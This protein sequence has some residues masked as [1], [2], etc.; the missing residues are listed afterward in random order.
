[1]K[2][3]LLC[4]YWLPKACTE[5]YTDQFTFICPTEKED[6][7]TQEQI[8]ERIGDCDVFFDVR[9]WARRDL[10]EAGKNLKVIANHAVG[11]DAIDVDCCNE[12]GIAVVLCATKVTETTAE[13]AVA[14]MM[15]TMRSVARYDREIRN[16]IWTSGPWIDTDTQ[17]F[18]H[19]LGVIGFG[20][21]GRAFAK[22]A[23]GLGMTIQ[24]YDPFRASPEVEREYEA[25]YL[26]LDEL[27][28]SSDCV[29]LHLPY[30][31]ENHNLINADAFAKMRDG[32]YLI[33][34]AR[35]P[36]VDE[37]AMIAALKSGKLRGAGLDVFVGEPQVNPELLKLPNVVMTPHAGSQTLETRVNMWNEG[38]EGVISVLNGKTPPNI[39]NP[40]VMSK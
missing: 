12:R 29:T 28:A 25:T 15:A 14:L 24:Y 20:R 34:A 39:V 36:I 9:D 17:L 38:M 33:N 19:T 8:K 40:Q 32:S 37:D 4:N 7:Y 23:R 11:Y 1:M 21:I 26:P 22:K 10:I 30:T 27:L 31:K 3:K 35:G 18:G 6:H 2:Y 5:P 13:L 16:G